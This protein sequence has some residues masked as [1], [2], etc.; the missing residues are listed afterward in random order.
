MDPSLKKQC[1]WTNRHVKKSFWTRIDIS[2]TVIM[3]YWAWISVQNWLNHVILKSLC[4]WRG[5]GRTVQYQHYG[6]TWWHD[7]LSSFLDLCFLGLHRQ[8]CWL[9]KL[10]SLLYKSCLTPGSWSHHGQAIVWNIF[11]NL[12]FPGSAQIDL[13]QVL[14]KVP[15]SLQL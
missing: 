12:L 9:N 3:S 10:S 7:S 5:L 6:C 1:C 8:H 15:E 13:F 4:F 2:S 14:T 11:W